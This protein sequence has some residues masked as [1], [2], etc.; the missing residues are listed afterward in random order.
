MRVVRSPLLWAAL[1]T[2]ATG[3]AAES[4][5]ATGVKVGEVTPNSALVWVRLTASPARIARR[6]PRRARSPPRRL[7]TA[8]S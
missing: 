4:H 7:P 5:Q 8:A 3:W 1:L 6:P 2:A